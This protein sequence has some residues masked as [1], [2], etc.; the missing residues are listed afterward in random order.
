MENKGMHNKDIQK[1]RRVLYTMQD[2]RMLEERRDFTWE[3]MRRTT[4]ALSGMPPGG[5]GPKGMEETFAKLSELDEKHAEKLKQYARELE[6]AEK[7][8]NGISRR[9]MRTFVS[10]AYL[11]GMSK[12]EVMEEL[13]MKEWEY[14]RARE[15][16]E[17]AKSMRDVPWEG[18]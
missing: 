9:S 14:R 4:K 5:G 13:N 3:S 11:F 15:K 18:P 2:I 7:I 10:M 12:D 6:E 16:I 17:K 8:I 1:L